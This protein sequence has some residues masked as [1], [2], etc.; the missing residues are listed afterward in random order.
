MFHNPLELDVLVDAY[1]TDRE[2]ERQM[3]QFLRQAGADTGV[4]AGL[5][6]IRRATG[7]GLIALGERLAGGRDGRVGNPAAPLRPAGNGAH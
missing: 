4:A 2:A 6:W 5:A 1:V 7:F 3:K